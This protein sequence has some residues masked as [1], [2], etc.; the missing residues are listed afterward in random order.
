MKEWWIKFLT[1]HGDRIVYLV[2]ALVM[3]CA[4]MWFPDLKESG[5]TILIGI[6]MLAYN[7]A[8]STEKEK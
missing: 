5:K 2:A 7:K 6:A 1:K 3:A 8:R 4:F